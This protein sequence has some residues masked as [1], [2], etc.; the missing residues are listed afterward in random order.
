MPQTIRDEFT[1]LRDALRATLYERDAEIDAT[2]AA[3]LA[4]E[5]VLLL[6]PPGTAKSLL[7]RLLAQ[8]I[9]GQ[10]FELLLTKFTTPEEVFGPVSVSAL[11][12]DRFQ[13]VTGGKLPE[14][15]V[16][17]LDE[18]W[19]AN[20]AILN[21]LLTVLN[22]RIYHNGSFGPVTCPLEIAITAS[23]ELPQDESLAA[24]YDRILVRMVVSPIRDD[25]AFETLLCRTSTP[26]IPVLSRA[27][28]AGIRA[29]VE[30]VKFPREVAATLVSLRRRLTT[31]RIVV[32]DRR[33]TQVVRYLK[34]VAWM[35]GAAKVTDDQLAMLSDILWDEPSQRPKV[36]QAILDIANPVRLQV[37]TL[38]DAA[39]AEWANAT[40]DDRGS[41]ESA[42]I[43][44]KAMH[45]VLSKLDANHPA[46]APALATLNELRGQVQRAFVNF[47]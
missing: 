39:T 17:V 5:H 23:N 15:E 13:R 35:D 18:V 12:G 41:V 28:L 33:W 26:T 6:G 34:A 43:K 24:L 32:S 27:S 4:R 37:L 9:A 21:S 44:I 20:S 22:E 30:A 3:L 42:G 19:K 45:T 14:A 36:E 2:L 40:H 29:E 7:A 25:D 10:Y 38:V 31:D 11:K 46:V 8:A 16:A 47:L 1:A